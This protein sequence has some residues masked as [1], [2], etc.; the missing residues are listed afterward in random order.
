ME[1]LDFIQLNLPSVQSRTPISEEKLRN[2]FKTFIAVVSIT[3][4]SLKCLAI[5]VLAYAVQ[6]RSLAHI[7]ATVEGDG[8]S[9]FAAGGRGGGSGGG[10]S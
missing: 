4:V 10:G 6:S 7:L 1:G 3:L 2:S 5:G 8:W 9:H